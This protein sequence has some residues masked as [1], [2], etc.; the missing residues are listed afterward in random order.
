MAEN[1]ATVEMIEAGIVAAEEV[2]PEEVV[3]KNEIDLGRLAMAVFDA[4]TAAQWRGIGTAPQHSQHNIMLG[5]LGPKGFEIG[6][7]RY[8]VENDDS[9]GGQWSTESWWGAPPTHWMPMPQA[10]RTTGT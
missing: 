8:V 3:E 7:G 9:S 4:M 2:I 6:I 1:L 10:P 5:Y